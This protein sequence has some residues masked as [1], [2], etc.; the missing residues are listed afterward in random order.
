MN[1]SVIFNIRKPRRFYTN[2]VRAALASAKQGVPGDKELV[3]EAVARLDGAAA[4][5]ICNAAG[6][7]AWSCLDAPGKSATQASALKALRLHNS[8]FFEQP[9]GVTP[10]WF[11]A[12][13]VKNVLNFLPDKVANGEDSCET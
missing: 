11:R 2:Y 7:T 13:G 9:G 4:G 10:T 5:C 3:N 6:H 1:Y 12:N 8:D